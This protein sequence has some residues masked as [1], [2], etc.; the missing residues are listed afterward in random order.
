MRIM[1]DENDFI[2]EKLKEC[3]NTSFAEGVMFCAKQIITLFNIKEKNH[4]N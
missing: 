2:S 4:E 3:E 1:L